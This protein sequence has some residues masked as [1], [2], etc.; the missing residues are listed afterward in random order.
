MDPGTAYRLS[1]MAQRPNDQNDEVQRAA[2]AP[3][4]SPFDSRREKLLRSLKEAF[5]SRYGMSIGL[6]ITPLLFF[7]FGYWVGASASLRHG[8]EEAQL[9]NRILNGSLPCVVPALG[10]GHKLGIG[11]GTVWGLAGVWT[12]VVMLGL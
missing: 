1:T 8:K 3:R 4:S 9:Q 11:S 12:L 6:I 5:Q 7:L 2:G 10:G